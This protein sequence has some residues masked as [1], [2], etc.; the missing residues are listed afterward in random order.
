M[1]RAGHLAL[2]F[3]GLALLPG[4]FVLF[5]DPEGGGGQSAGGTGG[6]LATT[7]SASA[8]SV[9][10]SGG[11]GVSGSGA[12][13]SSGNGGAAVLFDGMSGSVGFPSTNALTP[14]NGFTW[15]L[16]FFADAPPTNPAVGRGQT[17]FGVMDGAPCEDIYVGFGSEV[18]PQN[19]LTFVVD[20]N[21]GCGARDPDPARFVSAGGFSSGWHHVAA[22]ADYMVTKQTLLYFDGVPMDAK[23]WSHVPVNRTMTVTAGQWSDGAS[24]KAPFA[25]RIDELRVYDH[26][27][28][29][30]TILVHYA[31][32]KGTY[33]LSG[34]PGLIAG[35]HFDEGSGTTAGHF[36]GV[37]D[38]TLKLGASWAKG[39][40]AIP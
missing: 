26:A 32:G 27:L 11:V 20:G 5:H 3:V 4:C 19:E 12:G 34:D 6:T 13:G 28:S 18:S 31:S 38:G 16:W 40:V 23:K 10:V 21:G 2:S 39:I 22:V 37:G 14:T 36:G 24:T 17:I 7:A 9:T 29:A 25:G 15:E 1:L 30:A 8:T 33:G 35:W